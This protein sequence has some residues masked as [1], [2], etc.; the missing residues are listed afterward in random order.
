MNTEQRVNMLIRQIEE[1]ISQYKS[2]PSSSY[3][4]DFERYKVMVE[5]ILDKYNNY[6]KLEHL[7]DIELP[8]LIRDA[9]QL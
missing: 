4:N 6:E 8:R 2:K 5:T 3:L 7:V 9:R 1:C